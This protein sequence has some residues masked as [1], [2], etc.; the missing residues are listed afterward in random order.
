MELKKSRL[1]EKNSDCF[2]FKTFI[3]FSSL[4]WLWSM[5][6]PHTLTLTIIFKEIIK[7]HFFTAT[8]FPF[9]WSRTFSN[10]LC[11]WHIYTNAKLFFKQ[12]IIIAYQYSFKFISVHSLFLP[13]TPS[14]KENLHST[15]ELVII[16]ICWALERAT[17]IK[18]IKKLEC[19]L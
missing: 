9:H 11:E 10:M 15:S 12:G 13:S 14:T 7:L 19:Y 2:I 3:F 8:F 18:D 1:Q 4:W 5:I 16:P 6:W 17:H